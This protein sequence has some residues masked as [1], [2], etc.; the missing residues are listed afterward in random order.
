MTKRKIKR[1]KKTRKRKLK[2]Q[3]TKERERLAVRMIRAVETRVR[4]LM[5]MLVVN[6]PN[7]EERNLLRSLY[8][9]NKKKTV[10][11]AVRVIERKT[12]RRMRANPPLLRRE[13]R[14]QRNSD[15]EASSAWTWKM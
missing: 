4:T 14:S 13:N 2:V 8:R 11:V 6:E 3:Q 15:P 10:G 12:R 1:K 5:V 7:L 9:N